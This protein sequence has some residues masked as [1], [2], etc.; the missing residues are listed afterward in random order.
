MWCIKT[1]WACEP[2]SKH[3]HYTH[4]D[5]VNSLNEACP[6]TRSSEPMEAEG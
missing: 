6:H 4:K 5:F 1:L 3:C 2:K